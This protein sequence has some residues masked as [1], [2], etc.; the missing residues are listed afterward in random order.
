MKKPLPVFDDTKEM[1]GILL[2]AAI[3]LEL[4]LEPPIEEAEDADVE[5]PEDEHAASSAADAAAARTIAFDRYLDML[6]TTFVALI[7]AEYLRFAARGQ[8]RI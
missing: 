1:G 6:N 5:L 2:A 8:I 4:A 7:R 3:T